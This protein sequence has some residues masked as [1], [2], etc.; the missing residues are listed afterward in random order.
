MI[1]EE[2][3]RAN[4]PEICDAVDA[5]LRVQSR[6]VSHNDDFFKNDLARQQYSAS[7]EIVSRVVKR[8]IFEDLK[9]DFPNEAEN[10]KYEVAEGVSLDPRE[11]GAMLMV[12]AVL[13]E[14]L[15]KMMTF[16]RYLG[17][18]PSSKIF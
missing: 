12:Q 6:L 3:K 9:D 4:Y 16:D 11:H 5:L 15:I 13:S 1:D 10:F 17:R 18:R 8:W 2:W 7:E 14:S